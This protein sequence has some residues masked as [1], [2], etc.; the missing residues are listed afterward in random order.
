MESAKT[1]TLFKVDYVEQITE[2]RASHIWHLPEL[3]DGQSGPDKLGVVQPQVD[4]NVTVLCCSG[5][6]PEF[7]ALCMMLMSGFSRS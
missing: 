7:P 1:T 5:S 2:R 3:P 6:L 4:K